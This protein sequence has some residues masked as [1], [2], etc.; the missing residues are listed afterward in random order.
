M[1]E[2]VV[3]N[4]T[5]FSIN[6]S[7]SDFL[8]IISALLVMFSHYFN[9]KAQAGFELNAFE[10]CIRSQGGNVGVA[11]FFFLSG[12]GLMSSEMKS[13]LSAMQFFKRRFCKIYFPVLL[14]TAIWLPISYR[15]TLPHSYSLII[16]DLLWGFRDPVLWFIKSLILL[17][18]SFYLSTFYLKKNQPL[19]L[20]VLW[21]GTV[22]TCVISF[23][24]EY[25]ISGLPLFAVGVVSVLWPSR[26][27]ITLHPALIALLLSFFAV[28]I[29]LLCLPRFIPNL[30]HVLADY[31]VVATIIVVFS[32]WQPII[33]APAVLSLI[34]FDIYLVHFKVLVVM[35]A[36]IAIWS[37]ATFIIATLCFSLSLYLLRTKL[38]KI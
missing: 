9:L 28:S 19:G 1:Q 31:A 37:V 32:K 35:K 2:C 30:A 12:Y 5:H 36:I 13:H 20:A 7:V 27:F 21:T 18:G 33:K 24:C 16:R 25:S 38:I 23:L 29:S 4:N 6:R 17:Y 26:R 11:V 34:T 3:K 15:I 14:V 8:K 10:W 22:I